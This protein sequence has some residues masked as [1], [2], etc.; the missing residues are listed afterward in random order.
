MRIKRTIIVGMVKRSPTLILVV[1]KRLADKLLYQIVALLLAGLIVGYLVSRPVGINAGT[2]DAFFLSY[3]KAVAHSNERHM[4]YRSELTSDFQRFEKWQGFNTFW[5]AEG[6]ATAGQAFPTPGNP[7][8]FE[9]TVT[10]HPVGAAPWQQ[11]IDYY[12][13]CSGFT[14]T[15]IAK[16]AGCPQAD[17]RI[18]RL[19]WVN[20]A[21]S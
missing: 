18:D 12:L 10:F 16:I 2:A 11:G 5:D 8:E 6:Y 9:V 13:T 14:G 15:I 19:E 4:V 20:P 7:L 21:T 1:T 3:F 17:I